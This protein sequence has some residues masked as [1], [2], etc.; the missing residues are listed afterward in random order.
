MK[1]FSVKQYSQI[2][3]EIMEDATDKNLEK[4]VA[5]FAAFLRIQ[6]AQKKMLKIIAAYKEI[7]QKADGVKKLFI[8]SARPISQKIEDKLKKY[9]G[10]KAII[11]AQENPYLI[12]GIIVKTENIILDGSVKTQLQRMKNHL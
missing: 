6:L 2:L 5:G 7:A 3:F 4:R 11:T 8:M 9:F 10:D 12:G 1:K